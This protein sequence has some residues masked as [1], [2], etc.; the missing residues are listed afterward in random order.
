VKKPLYIFCNPKS[1]RYDEKKIGKLLDLARLQFGKCELTSNIGTLQTIRNAHVIIAGGDGTVHV[2][3]NEADLESN[4]FS[5]VAFGSGNDFVRNFPKRKMEDLLAEIEKEKFVSVDLLQ[6][7][8]KKAAVLAGIGFDAV[9]SD[10][11]HKNKWNIP[12]IKYMV[13]VLKNMFGYR[14]IQMKIK[15]KDLNYTDCVFM[16]SCGNGYRAGGGFKLF[17]KASLTDGKMDVLLIEPPTFWQKL[18][19]IWLVNFGKHLELNIVKYVQT[20]KISV[21]L[22]VEDLYN[23]DGDVY[24]SK[25][26]EISVLPGVFKLIM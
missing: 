24:R 12:A 13:P 9:V 10:A 23:T 14:G 5:V 26:M 11:A 15:G 8:D 16:L 19:Y 21:E 2:V 6:I 4:T 20:D 3:V 7:N 25:N 18:K 17:P 1:G 22:D